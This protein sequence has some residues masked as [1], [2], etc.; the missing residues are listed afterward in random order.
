LE[1]SPI[2]SLPVESA[3]DVES[4]LASPPPSDAAQVAAGPG[5]AGRSATGRRSDPRAFALDPPTS[6][7]I[8]NPVPKPRARPRDPSRRW[9]NIA[10][11]LGLVLAILLGA[12]GQ[13]L[14]SALNHGSAPAGGTESPPASAATASPTQAGQGPATPGATTA[15]VPTGTLAA[16]STASETSTSAPR[17]SGTASPTTVTFRDLMLDSAA[18]PAGTARTFAFT[19]DG[20]GS[21]S[22]Q[23]VT[24]A[25]LATLK[26]CLQVNS[27]SPSCVTGATP[28]FFTMA[29]SVGDQ[30]QWT[31]TLISTGAGSTPVVDVA[32]TWRTKSAAITLSHGRFQGSPNPDSLRGL[33]ATF[34]TRA[35]GSVGVV[36]AWPPASVD[37]A[38]T[39]TDVTA[40]PGS[41][42]DQAAYLAAGSIS[43][44]YSHAVTAGRTYQI[45]VLNRG[46][47]S[48]RPDLTTTISFP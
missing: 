33:T 12:T 1:D 42:V 38:L 44:A 48:G 47:D 39:L 5:A 9:R 7:P 13:L 32:F 46:S 29:P 4:V 14:F 16:T 18:D 40:T 8:A 21:V 45:Q 41:A 15:P 28:G 43:P 22:A 10:L 25:P 36:A 2:E 37:A 24:A 19:T 34:K 17:G 31:V 3:A 27:A 20:A 6:E 11:G 35:A 23:V 26:M 30:A